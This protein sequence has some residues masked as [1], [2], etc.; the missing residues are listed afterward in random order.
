MFEP[1][2]LRGAGTRSPGRSS[3]SRPTGW[4]G[5]PPLTRSGLQLPARGAHG[6]GSGAVFEVI[7]VVLHRFL[8]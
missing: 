6:V 7:L 4:A 1:A 5:G 3:L 8:W 2:L